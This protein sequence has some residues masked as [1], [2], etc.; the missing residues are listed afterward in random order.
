VGGATFQFGPQKGLSIS[1]RDEMESNMDI[2]SARLAETFEK[3]LVFREEEGTGAAGGIG[4][5]LSVAYDTKFVPGFSFVSKWFDLEKSIQNADL[6]LTGEGRFDQTSLM[7]KGPYEIIRMASRYNKNVIL[8]AG[9][10]DSD[11]KKKC[12]NAFSNLKIEAFGNDQF[13]LEENLLNASDL[14]QQKLNYY[15]SLHQ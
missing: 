3:P 9:S 7:G 6:I 2:M 15:L 8:L 5:G 12:M 4:Y 11:A 10:V 13:T 14:F 1:R